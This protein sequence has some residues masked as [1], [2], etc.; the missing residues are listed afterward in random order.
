MADR[1]SRQARPGSGDRVGGAAARRKSAAFRAAERARQ[2]RRRAL[3]WVGSAVAA[4]A[5]IAVIVVVAVVS[6]HRASGGR[7]RGSSDVAA[8]VLTGPPGPEGIVLEVGS[9]LA[10]AD[11]AATGQVVDG[12]RCNSMEQAV[13]HIHTH[14]SVYVNGALRP[15]PAGVGVV[16]PVPQQGSHGTFDSASRCYYWLHTHAQDGIIHVEA[17]SH[18]TY[19]LGQFFAIWRQPL[20]SGQVG[21]DRGPVIAYVNG[22]RYAGDPASIT[23]TSHE[24]VQLDVGTP[25]VAPRRVDW[26]HAQL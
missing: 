26:S 20:G 16:E 22:R 8:K 2:R 19:T 9:P 23:L 15:V 14:L 5:V 4:A 24:D 21:P 17:P 11:S 10:P 3:R 12:V 1:G 13:Y 25:T 7:A 18:A 6:G